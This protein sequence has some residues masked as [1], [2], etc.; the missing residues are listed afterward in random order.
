M[1]VLLSL[2]LVS[3][4]TFGCA[5]TKLLQATGGSKSDGV[6]ELAYQYGAFEKP[7]VDW[8][9]GLRTAIQRCSAW[10]YRGADPFG[11]TMSDCQAYDGYGGCNS[12]L[13]TVKYQCLD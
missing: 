10:G 7:V 12:W 1:K 5:T 3:F 11:G 13:V 8:D 4:L 9:A 2:F 6:V